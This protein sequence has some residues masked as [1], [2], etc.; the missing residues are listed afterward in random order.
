MLFRARQFEFVFPR[1]ALV[2]GIVN[3]T[4][5]SFSD[6]G[7]FFDADAAVAHGLALVVQGAE[8]LDI[9]GESTRPGAEPVS[10][11]EELRR[12][13]PVIEALAAKTKAVLSIDT[14]KPA[15]ARAALASGA[16][17][18]ND[19][20]AYRDDQAMWQVVAESGAG[21][22]C[23]HAQ[24]PPATMQNNP[25][26]A[27]VVREVES[28]FRHRLEKLNAAGVAADQI[29]FDPGIGFGKTLKHNL[30]LLAGLGRFV[31]LNRPVL[32]GVSRKSF[33]QK[34]SG[35]AGNER[36]PASL[37]CATL[38]IG[39]GVQII[40]THDAGET[41]HALRLAEAVLNQKADA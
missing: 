33:L 9:G 2:M 28:F 27:D 13:I 8:I 14:L 34:F 16:S 7:K 3:V 30:Q 36:L 21:Y 31:S 35:A 17:I 37:A 39:D 6:G 23:M 41:V 10:E 15:V 29:V 19:V 24:G 25:V 1:P 11:I 12:V 18:V 22:I 26:Y 38:A 20:G 32:L 5:D 4:P 40:R